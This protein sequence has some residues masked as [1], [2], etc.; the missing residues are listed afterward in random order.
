MVVNT[1]KTTFQLFSLSTKHHDIQLQF[2]DK[3]LNRIFDTVYLGI[4]LNTKLTWTKHVNSAVDKGYARSRLLKRL[5]SATWGS[6]QDVLCTAYKSYVRPVVEY[7]NEALITASDSIKNKFDLFQNNM[8]RLITGGATSTSIV[9]M[10][11]QIE[12]EP[13]N[14]RCQSAAIN[15]VEKIL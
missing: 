1:D 5:A 2:N 8:L 12:L 9:A 7:G 14:E 13:L 10:E 6:T 15:L 11:L 3:D 4:H